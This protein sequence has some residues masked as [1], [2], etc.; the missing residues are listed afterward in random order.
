MVEKLYPVERNYPSLPAHPAKNGRLCK[1]SNVIPTSIV[2]EAAGTIS[3]CPEFNQCE[4]KYILV[5]LWGG[6]NDG[7]AYW[8]RTSGE[9]V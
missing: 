6:P 3:Y 4:T 7:D 5:G 8:S 2:A 1:G 9:A